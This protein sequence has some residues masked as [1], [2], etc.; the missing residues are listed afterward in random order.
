M[1]STCPP[2]AARMTGLWLAV[3]HLL[4][5]APLSSSSA[6]TSFRSASTATASGVYPLRSSPSTS[7]PPA[8]SRA[9]AALSPVWHAS[10][11]VAGAPV[12]S[13]PHKTTS[14]VD[15]ATGKA[16]LL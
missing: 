1:I 7:V 6:T 5:S 13:A 11:N 2:L 14:N 12:A 9:T 10:C 4:T 16:V 3:R 8:S 15:M